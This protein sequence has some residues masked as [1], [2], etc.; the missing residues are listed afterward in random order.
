M[1]GQRGYVSLND[2]LLD[3]V[4]FDQNAKMFDVPRK[5]SIHVVK[6]C[7]SEHVDGYSNCASYYYVMVDTTEL[8]SMWSI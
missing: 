2:T 3:R 1:R 5:K 4:R 8:V 7:T 6:R